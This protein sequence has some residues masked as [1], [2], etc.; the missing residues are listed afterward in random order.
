MQ[1]VIVR[2]E[3]VLSFSSPCYVVVSSFKVVKSAARSKRQ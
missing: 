2:V 1:I 3:T